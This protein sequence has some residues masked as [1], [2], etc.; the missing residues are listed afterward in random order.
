MMIDKRIVRAKVH[1][2]K[3]KVQNNDPGAGSCRYNGATGSP[4]ELEA[5][6]TARAWARSG[7]SG[8]GI[9]TIADSPEGVGD[10]KGCPHDLERNR[11]RERGATGGGNSPRSM[12]TSRA[13]RYPPAWSTRVRVVFKVLHAA[14]ATA[15]AATAV[16]TARALVSDTI[17]RPVVALD[18][19]VLD[20]VALVGIVNVGFELDVGARI[21]IAAPGA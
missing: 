12:L 16:V 15:P 8:S 7:A 18:A 3:I 14:S 9:S 21:V 20:V 2:A 19:A 17:R 4:P 11:S 6:A 1:T 13:R 5:K 10:N